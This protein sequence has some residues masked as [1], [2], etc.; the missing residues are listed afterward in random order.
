MTAAGRLSTRHLRDPLLFA[1]LGFGSGLL[2]GAPGT[3]GSL[4]GVGVY[5]LVVPL[6][7]VAVTAVTVIVIIAGFPLCGAAAK[8]LG[9]HDHPAIVW[10]EIAGILLVLAFLPLTWYWLVGGFAAFRLFDAVKPWPIRW[11]DRR[12]AGGTGIMLDDLA[13]ALVSLLV[14]FGVGAGIGALAG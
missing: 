2:P 8:R 11:L 13:A 3:W 5:L 10:D 4:V 9:L 7:P 6:G 1:A 14:L 12:I